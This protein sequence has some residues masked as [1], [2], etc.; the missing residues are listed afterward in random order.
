MRPSEPSKSMIYTT[1]VGGDKSNSEA[2]WNKK[3]PKPRTQVSRFTRTATY[4][5]VLHN[6]VIT[7]GTNQDRQ[8]ITLVEAIPSFIHINHYA[9]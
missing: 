1:D 7:S 8:L 4:E 6:K 3:K 5:S 9:D 2:T